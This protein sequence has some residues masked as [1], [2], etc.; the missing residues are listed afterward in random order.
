[1][2]ACD[3]STGVSHEPPSL[4]VIALSAEYRI[5]PSSSPTDPDTNEPKLVSVEIDEFSTKTISLLVENGSLNKTNI[6]EK[7]NASSFLDVFSV[8][9]S[10]TGL[11]LTIKATNIDS[12]KGDFYQLIS[13]D[14]DINGADEEFLLK[15]KIKANNPPGL[16]LM[17]DD[18]EYVNNWYR[19]SYIFD[20]YDVKCTFFISHFSAE[21]VGTEKEIMLEDL[22]NSG[23]EIAF[24]STSHINANT[25]ISEFGMDAYLENEI[26]NDLGLLN[27][28]GYEVESFAYP[29]GENSTDVS[30]SFSSP[31]P[32]S[33][34]GNLY[35]GNSIDSN[36]LNFV[37]LE[38]AMDMAVNQRRDLILYAHNIGPE[39][40]S[41]QSE[42]IKPAELE[43]VLQMA[44]QK[45]LTFK[46]FKDID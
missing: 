13:V 30:D 37:E 32:F 1:L 4:K 27:Y 14:Y 25:Y 28:R 40:D 3:S 17:F 44:I 33:V 22:F 5:S 20:T 43:R 45:G 24:H 41:A 39:N 42:F 38:S 29:F 23:H 34:V 18:G 35:F 36:N 2:S 46:R 16:V 19:Y 15:V 26:F 6:V 7:I 21:I 11:I 31:A 10:D 9:W 12:K 8:Q